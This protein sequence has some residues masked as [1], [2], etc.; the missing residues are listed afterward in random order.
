MPVV[1]PALIWVART[2]ATVIAGEVI[3]RSVEEVIRE[4]EPIITPPP[5]SDNTGNEPPT[6]PPWDNDPYDEP[7]PYPW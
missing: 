1:V 7:E 2:V 5:T 3:C 4:D 6:A